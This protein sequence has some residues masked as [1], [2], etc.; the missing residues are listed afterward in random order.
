MGSVLSSGNTGDGELIGSTFSHFG[1]G[2]IKSKDKMATRD[3]GHGTLDGSLFG[4][5]S[6]SSTSGDDKFKS[7]R[8][9]G[10]TIFPRRNSH[11]LVRKR[12]SDEVRR[13]GHSVSGSG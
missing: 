2:G 9:S 6:S 4:S 5:G 7:S 3:L 11:P 1:G 12:E 13:S 8:R 10:S